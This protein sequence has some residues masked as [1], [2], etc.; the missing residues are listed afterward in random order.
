MKAE[1]L[2]E[3]VRDFLVRCSRA[4]TSAKPPTEFLCGPISVSNSQH[5]DYTL[6]GGAGVIVVLVAALADRV[7][8]VLLGGWG[9]AG[10]LQC[11]LSPTPLITAHN[12]TLGCG[13]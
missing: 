4:A 5:P 12:D 10:L 1:L 9:G 6:V 8:G 11:A 3:R 13:G 7:D 2:A